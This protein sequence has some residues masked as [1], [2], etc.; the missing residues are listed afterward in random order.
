MKNGLVSLS[1]L[2]CFLSF[3]RGFRPG[4]ISGYSTGNVNNPGAGFPRESGSV[5]PSPW[6]EGRDEGGRHANS[7]HFKPKRLRATSRI[8]SKGIPELGSLRNSSARRSS[9]AA[10]FTVDAGT[11]PASTMLLQTFCASSRRSARDRSASISVFKVFH[12]KLPFGIDGAFQSWKP[13]MNSSQSRCASS[14]RSEN[15]SLLAAAKN[16]LT[17][18]SSMYSAESPAQAAVSPFV[19][20]HSSFSHA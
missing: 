7:F 13:S 18:I 6:G 3:G 20:R 8:C 19:I 16:F 5:S 9:S 2:T 1:A 10:C 14:I 12:E 17:D 15:G 11:Y 4:T